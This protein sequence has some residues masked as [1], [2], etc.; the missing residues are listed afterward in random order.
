MEQSSPRKVGDRESLSWP[1]DYPPFMKP[2]GSVKC[3]YETATGPYY[4][5][6]G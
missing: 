5:P 2:E 6:V 3:V 1:R 4:G